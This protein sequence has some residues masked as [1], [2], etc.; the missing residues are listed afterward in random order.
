MV[1]FQWEQ[2]PTGSPRV[3][4][5]N[6]G[7]KVRF[8]FPNDNGVSQAIGTTNFSGVGEII[9]AHHVSSV[10]TLRVNGA[11][12]ITKTT[13][14]TFN[15]STSQQFVIAANDFG[16]PLGFCNMDYAELIIYNA[17]LSGSDMSKIESYMAIKYGVTLGGN[18]SGI[19]YVSAYGASIWDANTTYHN[20]VTGI[21]K[22]LVVQT[23]DQ[24]KSQSINTSSTMPF[25]IAH[26]S[27][28]SPTSIS[29]DNSYVIVG[30][31]D[32]DITNNIY[33][34]YTHASTAIEKQ[35][36]RIFRIQTTNLPTGKSVNELEIEIDM[37]NVPGLSGGSGLGV[38]NAAADLRLL[39]DDNTTFGQGTANE[40]AYSNSGVSGN[41]IRFLIPF[42]DL[43]AN[44]VY[45]LQLVQLI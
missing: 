14:G 27:I 23:L 11:V 28:T 31:D 17:G 10:S 42:S 33:V 19:G 1:Y 20:D 3:G 40:R 6:S 41:L 5:E 30:H 43:P 7:G 8:D 29:T 34:T 35:L 13:S 12:D 26:N 16:N 44:G 24:P 4:F 25:T 38:A 22:D 9:T 39:L 37:S 45:F 15:N 36:R 21:A 32:G 18:G 2:C